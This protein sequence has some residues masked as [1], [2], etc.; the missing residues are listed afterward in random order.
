MK[1]LSRESRQRSA[2][3]GTKSAKHTE[4]FKIPKYFLVKE[5][6]KQ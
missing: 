1:R 6:G 2:S 3:P 5:R 4:I